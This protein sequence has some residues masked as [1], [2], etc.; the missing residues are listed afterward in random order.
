MASHTETAREPPETPLRIRR[1]MPGGEPAT[2]AEIVEQAGLWERPAGA[3]AGRPRVLLNMVSSADGRATLAGRSGPISSPADRALFHGLRLPVDAVLAGAGTVRAERYGRI[4]REEPRRRQ[5]VERGLSPEPIACIV[6]GSLQIDPTIPLLA[7]PEVHAVVLTPSSASLPATGASVEYIR[8]G[9]DGTLD[10]SRALAEL[11]GR[12][13]V[14]SVLCEGG[15]HLARELLGAGLL[16]ELFLSLAPKLAG[17]DE[18]QRAAL[19]ILAGSELAPGVE[20]ELISVLE[21]DSHL[22]LRY[23]VLAPERVSRETM[24][25]SSLAR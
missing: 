22:F 18:G 23:G 7:E 6:S 25:S 3:S 9:S 5:R 13:A 20:L 21:C 14:E 17:G 15:P 1:L 8:A 11:H 24:L 2:V 12:F 4:I 16:D 10:L 19:R